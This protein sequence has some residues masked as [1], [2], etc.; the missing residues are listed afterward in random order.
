MPKVETVKL[1]DKEVE[2]VAGG[3]PPVSE[4]PFVELLEE[5]AEFVREVTPPGPPLPKLPK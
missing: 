3:K 1:D 2:I 4:N 5:V